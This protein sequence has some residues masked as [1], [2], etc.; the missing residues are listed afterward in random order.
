MFWMRLIRLVSTYDLVSPAS[1]GIKRFKYRFNEKN[2]L[3]CIYMFL[4]GWR[5]KK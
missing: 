5:E 3:G 4:Q 1:K 2:P